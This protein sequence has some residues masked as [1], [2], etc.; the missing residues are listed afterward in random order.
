M[1]AVADDLEVHLGVDPR[2]DS[3]IARAI[4]HVHTLSEANAARAA[5]AAAPG[6]AAVED[7]LTVS[8]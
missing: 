4:A 8:P 7:F 5:A 3:D 6:V 1:R 2:D